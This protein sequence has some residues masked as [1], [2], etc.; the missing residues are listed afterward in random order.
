MNGDSARSV[1]VWDPAVRVFHWTLVAA[2][3]TAWL[4]GDELPG[5][6]VWTGYLIAGLLVFRLLWGLVGPRYA[7]F[8][9]FVRPPS[10]VLGY[11]DAVRRGRAPRYLGHNPAG[12][13]MVV[14]L[15]LTLTI[16]AASGLALLG[17][18]DFSGPLAGLVRGGAMADTLE[19]VHEAAA[20]LTLLLVALHLGGV[21]FSSLV[22]GENLIRSMIDGRKR[23]TLT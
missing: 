1:R 19:E 22:H 14:A 9:E 10:A 23:E 20:N 11:L 6:H 7:R 4:S 3:A 21:L 12:G 8:G 2:F 17:A 5:I 15:I 13:A 18:T 16:T